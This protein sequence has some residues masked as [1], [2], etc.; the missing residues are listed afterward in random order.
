MTV[1]AAAGAGDAWWLYVM[2]PVVA[3]LIGYVTK[4]AA[5]EMMFWPLKF[6]GVGPVGWQGMVPRRATKVAGLAVDTLTEQLLDPRELIDRL[7]AD[8]LVA[9][10]EP[11]LRDLIP[12]IAEELVGELHPDVWQRLPA[13]G[14]ALIVA[15]VH[16]RAPD[17]AAAVLD[18]VRGRLDE[19]VDLRA[20]VVGNLLRDKR[21]LA[22]MVRDVAHPELLFIARAG[23]LFGAVL[24]SVQALAWWA[25]HSVLIMPLFGAITGWL[26][27]WLALTLVFRPVRPMGIG[28]LRWQGLFH[29]RREGV[30]ETCAR[31]VAEEV[32]TPQ[33]LMIA[34][35]E[36]PT[37]DR[38]LAA[39]A[40][41]VEAAFKQGTRTVAP[42]ISLLGGER[43]ERMK[44]LVS[45][46]AVRQ[47]PELAPHATAYVDG[48]ID[49][50]E[51]VRSRMAMMSNDQFESI[52][53][54]IFKEDERA[55]IA[56]GA[57]LGFLIGEVQVELI[58]HLA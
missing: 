27:D 43:Y 32:L 33:T 29:K 20:I 5:I 41:E 14:R 7:D 54:P 10:M 56:V 6:R 28:R 46:I 31:L 53:R 9:S 1:L 50:E 48:A 8:A 2:F 47:A 30:T 52:L 40:G 44:Q 11:A 42:V 21:W 38:F 16:D 12:R 58:T 34:V 39:I 51:L 23:I 3:A 25:T 49:V 55:L 24:G 15:R 18:D 19:I 26:T 13:S 37:A 22:R 35:L 17:V 45:E 57:V 36:G 4:R